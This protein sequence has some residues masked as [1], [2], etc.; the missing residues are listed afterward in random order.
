MEGVSFTAM[1]TYN[2]VANATPLY[3][4]FFINTHLI[5]AFLFQKAQAQQLEPV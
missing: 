3:L 4:H 2:I 1:Q 5:L